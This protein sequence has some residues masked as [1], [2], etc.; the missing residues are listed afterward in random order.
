MLATIPIKH[1]L[2]IF[3]SLID[4]SYSLSLLPIILMIINS[5]ILNNM[6][7]EPTIMRTPHS[8]DKIKIKQNTSKSL[9]KYSPNT[10]SPNTH[11]KISQK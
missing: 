5:I 8:T 7:K 10:P 2:I 1:V 3:L 4:I 6:N 9:S 11:H